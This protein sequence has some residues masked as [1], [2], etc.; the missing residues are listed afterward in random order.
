[1]HRSILCRKKENE[2]IVNIVIIN[3]MSIFCVRIL[4]KRI[5]YESVVISKM[6]EESSFQFIDTISQRNKSSRKLG[7]IKGIKMF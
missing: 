5:C 3:T 1:M 7:K 4:K 2:K 6:R